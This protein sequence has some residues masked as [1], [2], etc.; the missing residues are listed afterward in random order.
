MYRLISVGILCATLV[1]G[2]P[3]PSAAQSSDVDLGGMI[4]TVSDSRTAQVFHI[5]DQLSQWDP[6]THREYVR[7]AR[8]RLV[9]SAEDSALLRR[10]AE[11]RRA[12]GWGNGFE[13]AFLVDAPIRA[14]AERAVET[15]LLSAAES[16]EETEILLHFAPKV[17]PLLQEEAGRIDAFRKQLA[18]ERLRLTPFVEQ[19]AHFADAAKPVRVP[20]FLV[21]NP[22]ET[23]G[24]GEANGGRLVIEVPSPEPMG[25]LL[26]EAM[27]VFLDPH[28]DEIRTAADSAGV[29]SETLNE[30][31][32]YALAP[33]ITDDGT[34]VDLL[35]EQVAEFVRQGRPASDQYMQSY[36][37][38]TVIRPVLRAALERGETLRVFLPQAVARWRKVAQ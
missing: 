26:H 35:A 2:L 16:K 9:L 18:A 4:L 30:A 20:V 10:H 36:L 13:Q 38:A 7:W 14:A 29:S 28:A 5:V 3:A 34:Q 8:T 24:G 22:E 6:H 12:R 27:H 25:F 31:I 33:G 37:M 23:S 15:H 32:A 11:L 19:L 1:P 17:E 21:A